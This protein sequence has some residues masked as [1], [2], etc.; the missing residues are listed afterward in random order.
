MNEDKRQKTRCVGLSQG[1]RA[2]L[3]AAP[4]WTNEAAG[5]AKSRAIQSQSVRHPR[6]D[7]FMD[8]H[9]ATS[10]DGFVYEN[11]VYVKGNEI[12]KKRL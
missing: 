10:A 2:R 12:L 5:P 1:G 7:K 9:T 11:T 8:A 4:D 3:C 6:L